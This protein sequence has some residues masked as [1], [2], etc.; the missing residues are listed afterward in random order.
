MAGLS[1][2]NQ[3]RDVYNM[4]VVRRLAKRIKKEYP[5]FNEGGFNRSIQEELE[6][7][8]FGERATLITDALKEYL[9]KEFKHSA[10]IILNTLE[11]EL[12]TPAGDAV[13][14]GFITVPE[15]GYIVER[16]MEHFSLSMKVFHEMTKRFSC[17]WAIRAF[18][19][20]YPLLLHDALQQFTAARPKRFERVGEGDSLLELCKH[21]N[22]DLI[23]TFHT[24]SIKRNAR[25][26]H[27]SVDRF[28]GGPDW[29]SVTT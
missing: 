6:P 9:P 20:K 5:A 3:L 26:I 14:D 11:P 10:R 28:L 8:G 4:R 12:T 16:G 15:S 1:A 25:R 18:I 19:E 24:G 22:M 21:P 29:P 17:E 23:V 13:W 7:L 2:E 27:E